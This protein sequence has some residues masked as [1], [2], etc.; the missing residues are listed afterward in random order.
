M[1]SQRIENGE[2]FRRAGAVVFG[3]VVLFSAKRRV[4]VL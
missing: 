1:L 4:S 3:D 2:S